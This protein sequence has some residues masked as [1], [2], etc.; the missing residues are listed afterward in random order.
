MKSNS[1][2]NLKMIWK[3]ENKRTEKKNKRTTSGMPLGCLGRQGPISTSL[4]TAQRR[5]AGPGH[6]AKPTA[7]GNNNREKRKKKK[8]GPRPRWTWTR[9]LM[10]LLSFWPR[11]QRPHTLN[12]TRQPTSEEKEAPF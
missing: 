10:L 6:W 7:A 4:S 8:K 5:V 2:S 12:L 11:R 3:K 1:N 9:G